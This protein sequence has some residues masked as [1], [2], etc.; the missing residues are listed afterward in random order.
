[1]YSSFQLARK[2][3]KYYLTASNGKGHGIHSPFV[4]DLVQ[5]VLLN[6]ENS[7]EY[8]SAEALRKQLLNNETI[9][10]VEDFGAGS[11]HLKYKKR[12]VK[13]IAATSLKPEKYARLL[14]NIVKYFKP[15]TVV[16]LGTS[17]GVTTVYLAKDAQQV[18]TFEGSSAIAE[19]A[20]ENF[21]QLHLTHIEIVVGPFEKNLPAFFHKQIQTDLVFLDGNHRKEPTLNYFYQ[22]LLSSNE[23]SIFV[24]DDIHWSKEME[25]AWEAIKQDAAVTLTVDLFFVGLVLFRRDFKVKQHFII[26]Y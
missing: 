26:R 2:Y 25:E 15:K 1:M 16:E 21:R 9:L 18:F 20:S 24:F 11:G 5:H 17:L 4:F 3:I 7:T 8:E 13:D 10:E 23:Y 19:I 22:F 12:K 6:K 14:G